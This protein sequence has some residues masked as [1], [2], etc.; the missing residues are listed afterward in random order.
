MRTAILTAIAAEEARVYG[1]SSKQA[2]AANK[3]IAK[4]LNEQA[5]KAAEAR[6][7][8]VQGFID[9]VVK[10]FS[11][12]FK[13]MITGT[14]SF[15][16][17]MG[18]MARDMLAGFADMLLGM[19]EKWVTQKLLELFIAKTT[20]VSEVGTA[21][22]VGGAGAAAGAATA[23]W[24]N[25]AIAVGFGAA[26]SGA[27]MGSFGGVAAAAEGGFD[28][29]SF[30][31]PVTKL[32]P[33]EMVLPKGLANKIRGMTGDGGGSSVTINVTTF[34]SRSFEQELT[35]H[36]SALYRVLN[37]GARAGRV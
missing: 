5:K 28:V 11:S 20:A 33:E 21:A 34:D 1:L 35:R 15:A 10:A 14:K 7:A 22:A 8:F 6:K 29:P 32:H 25:P 13:A 12:G 3:E 2:Q 30:S 37:R 16:Q 19:A 36:D 18:D 27:I 9:P 4:D 24:W 26:M 17:A 31:S 23:F